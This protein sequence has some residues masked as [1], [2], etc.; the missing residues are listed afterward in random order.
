MT[1][2]EEITQRLGSVLVQEHHCSDQL[3]PCV[4]VVL[5]ASEG[6][7]QT[8]EL[9]LWSIA[10]P[11]ALQDGEAD[12]LGEILSVHLIPILHCPFCGI[13]LSS[14]IPRG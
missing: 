14:S 3:S 10:S 11:C 5:A 9:I 4:A 7:M 13:H 1:V 12:A 6:S 2:P 8:W